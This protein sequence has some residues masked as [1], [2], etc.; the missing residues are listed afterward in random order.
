MA[1]LSF[2]LFFQTAYL[3][4][5]A[6]ERSGQTAHASGKREV[7]VRQGT[8]DKM[9]RVC[10]D[11]AAL[12][13]RVDGQIES[14]QLVELRIV[15]AEH[16]GEVRAPVEFGVDR[17]DIAVLVGVAVDDGGDCGKLGD[18]VHGVFVGVLCGEGWAKK[19]VRYCKP[20][21]FHKLKNYIH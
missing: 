12:V 3:V 5:K 6:M 16:V 13:V 21:D 18:Q 4:G 1:S 19:Q 2:S 10:G 14:E 7:R 9:A 17:S 8:A 11:V 15:V 20:V